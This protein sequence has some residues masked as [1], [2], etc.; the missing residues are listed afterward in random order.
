MRSQD[1]LDELRSR[2]D[3]AARAG[4]ARFGIR[5]ARVLGGTSVPTLRAMAKRIGR[6]HQTAHALWASGIHEA[7]LLATMV[8]D[9]A[10]VTDEQM[11]RWARDFDSWDLVDGACSN[12][13][14]LTPHAWPKAAQWSGREEE[15]VKRAGFALMAT[16]AVHDRAAS[17]DRFV[18]LLP[19]IEREAADPR[20]F[21]RKAVNWALR[22]VGRRNA[23]LHRAAIATCERILAGGPGPARWVASDALRELT[24]ERVR[25]VIAGR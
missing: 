4:M 18:E 14:R 24:S 12:L 9:P 20:N 7:R 25:R 22:Q 11:E 13:F 6:D 5:G 19:I 21:V 15:F 3:P 17:D 8:E 23:V 16:L 2:A 10:A 1:I